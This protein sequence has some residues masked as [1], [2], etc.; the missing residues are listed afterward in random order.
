[1]KFISFA[2]KLH[3]KAPLLA[4]GHID[5]CSFFKYYFREQTVDRMYVFGPNLFLNPTGVER[6]VL[7]KRWLI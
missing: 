5:E 4:R 7:V 2:K 3:A 1:M 6:S